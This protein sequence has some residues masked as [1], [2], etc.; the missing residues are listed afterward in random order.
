EV[1]TVVAVHRLGGERGAI[2]GVGGGDQLA[3]PPAAVQVADV[4]GQDVR[5]AV[6]QVHVHAERPA[7]HGGVD[8]VVGVA[9]LL[10]AARV[11]GRAGHDVRADAEVRGGYGGRGRAAVSH[12]EGAVIVEV[13]AVLEPRRRVGAGRVRLVGEGHR[14]GVPDSHRAVVPEAGRRCHVLDGD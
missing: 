14:R 13:V 3:A 6:G 7:A 5:L 2:G 1:I 10:E 11:R 8:A 4:Q 12:L 9:P